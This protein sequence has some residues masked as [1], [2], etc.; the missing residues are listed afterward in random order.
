LI[1]P[2]HRTD[3]RGTAPLRIALVGY[4]RWGANVARDLVGT[5]GAALTHVVD[6]SVPALRRAAAR[7][8]AI[9]AATA[10]PGALADVDAVVVC[11]PGATH[12]GL[13][14]LA[15]AASK[16]VFVE[17][18]FAMSAA[19]AEQLAALAA[20]SGLALAVGHQLLYHAAFEELRRR[21][22]SGA[23]GALRAVRSERAGRIDAARDPGVLWAYGPHDVAM[24][25]ALVGRPPFSVRAVR[26]GAP[27]ADE[28]ALQLDFDGAVEGRIVLRGRAERS[29]RRLTAVCE[30]GE[31]VFDELAPTAAVGG[32]MPL[33]RELSAFVGCARR[34]GALR[35]D[36][37]HGLSV[38]R[39]LDAAAA[40]LATAPTATSSSRSP[41]AL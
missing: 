33:A 6:V 25:L 22:A 28:I 23:L 32:E 19:D 31:I 18:P 2:A 14:A 9:V 15:L 35:N 39:V 29:V 34:G 13:A 16:H 11:T 41:R 37:G 30:R 8:P 10:L 12:A 21:V 26:G 36:G 20:A 27:G 38:T 24:A 4:G 5:D 40:Q 7:H 3:A 17:K 1:E